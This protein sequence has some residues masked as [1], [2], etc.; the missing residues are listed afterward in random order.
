MGGKFPNAMVTHLPRIN[1]DHC[2]IFLEFNKIPAGRN[3][4]FRFET[5]LVYG[6]VLLELGEGSVGG[7]QK[8]TSCWQ[9]KISRRKNESG[10]DWCLAMWKKRKMS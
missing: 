8:E 6:S 3:K 9:F 4:P 7:E 5:C 2:L 1:S 10:I